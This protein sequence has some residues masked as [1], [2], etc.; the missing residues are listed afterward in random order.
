M[1]DR[2]YGYFFEVEERFWWNVATRRAFFRMLAAIAPA[3]AARVVDVGCGT[4]IVL[5][6]FP[7]PAASL[8]GCDAAALALD[9]TR[10]R[11]IQDL[12]RGDLGALPFAD[13][14][15]D[16][17]LALDVIEHLDD[18][19]AALAELAR[20]LRPGDISCCTSRRSICSGATRTRST[21][22]AAATAVQA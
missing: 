20:I 16:L 21:I 1:D 17:V 9:L 18:D 8:I 5:R 7:W 6:E 22:T 10:K 11:G 19:A 4:G 3:P 12:V 15:L 14:S 13:R 2:L